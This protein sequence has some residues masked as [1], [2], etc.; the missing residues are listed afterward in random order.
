MWGRLVVPVVNAAGEIVG[1]SGRTLDPDWKTKG[2]PKWLHSRNGTWMCRNVF[3]ANFAAEHIQKTETAIICEGAFD[4]LRLEQAG[5]HNGVAVMGRQLYNEQMTVLM[6]MG[7]TKLIFALDNDTAGRMGQSAAIKMARCLFTVSELQIP[8]EYKDLGEM[9]A[10]ALREL[11]YG[12][13]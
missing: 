4:V 10:E 7:A 2:I 5:V 8:K 11:V 13:T 12:R 6:S 3:N 1:F 9:P